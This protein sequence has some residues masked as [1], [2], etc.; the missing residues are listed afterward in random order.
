MEYPTTPP[1]VLEITPQPAQGN[2]NGDSNLSNDFSAPQWTASIRCLCEGEETGSA[3]LTIHNTALASVDARKDLKWFMEDHATLDPFDVTRANAARRKLKEFE[4][5]LA[6]VIVAADV[7]PNKRGSHLSV[8]VQVLPGLDHVLYA[9][10]WEVL[11][12]ALAWA[13]AGVFYESYSVERVF[14]LQSLN[15]PM[16][17]TQ[18]VVVEQEKEAQE[19]QEKKQQQYFKTNILVMSARPENVEGCAADPISLP[20]AKIVSRYPGVSRRATLHIARPGTWKAFVKT[21]QAKPK[22]F[23]QFVHID[24]HGQVE[25]DE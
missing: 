13:F 18:D 25:N 23:Y 7:L 3:T 9:L 10:P 20:I 12:D 16:S 14:C 19:K 15:Q 6:K 4:L 2:G 24:M 22:G 17:T 1:V 8:S 11:G 5:E 21:L